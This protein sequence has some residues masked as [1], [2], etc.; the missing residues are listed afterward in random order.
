MDLRSPHHINPR[1]K[2]SKTVQLSSK[3]FQQDNHS[4]LMK[5]NLIGKNFI[6]EHKEVEIYKK[7]PISGKLIST[8]KQKIQRH[9][10]S[11]EC[12]QM[13]DSKVLFRDSLKQNC[14]VSKSPGTIIVKKNYQ[15]SRR[16]DFGSPLNIKRQA[17]S[18][19]HLRY[20]FVLI[21]FEVFEQ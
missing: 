21:N 10:V 12:S 19:S 18:I 11:R 3:S 8:G 6:I 13:A 20:F 7:D 4:Q 16:I 17:K 9:T 2:R 5:T 14:R 15:K 1:V